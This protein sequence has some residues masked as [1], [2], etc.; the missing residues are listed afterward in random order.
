[1]P[2][3]T[4]NRAIGL[5]GIPGP[6]PPRLDPGPARLDPGPLGHGERGITSRLQECRMVA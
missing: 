2:H 6:G 3:A 1:M 4:D 5:R